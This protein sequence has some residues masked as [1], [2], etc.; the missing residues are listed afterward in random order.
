M[1]TKT[2]TLGT[3]M[4][5]VPDIGMWALDRPISSS[6]VHRTEFC[7]SSC[8][9]DKLY[10]L[11]PAMYGKDVR[12]E[13]AW[14]EN[15]AQDLASCLS[16]K[17][18]G[19]KNRFRLMTRGESISNF[20]DIERVINIAKELKGY[21][22]WVPTRS[23]RSPVLFAMAQQAFRKYPNIILMASM[24]PSNSQEEWEHVKNLNLNTMFFGDDDMEV[25]P[26]GDKVFK[27]P[28]THKHLNGHCAICK[29]GCFTTRNRVDVHLK[30]H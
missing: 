28:K 13:E 14:Q 20:S 4:R 23:W 2:S 10:K 5:F 30:Q 29:G 9:N 19:S 27:C 12:N 21:K 16:R 11:Y 24:D 7:E 8:Y 1:N 18:K 22:I 3:E 25:T 26:N 15:D 6:C 17:K